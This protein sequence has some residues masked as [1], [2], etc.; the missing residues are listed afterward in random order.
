MSDLAPVPLRDAGGHFV[1]GQSGN[2]RGR[3]DARF[4][5][6]EM[7]KK[8]GPE[9]I[10]VI[11]DLLHDEDARIR[12]T[13]ATTLLDRGFGRPVQAVADAT[14]GQNITFLHLVAARAIS[15]QIN[16]TPRTID[17]ETTDVDTAQKPPPNLMEPALE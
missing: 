2:P 12:L 5:I 17:A 15:E 11:A 1:K 8:Y 13:A 10:R 9:C 14:N 6:T 4:D 7:A 16:G 3:V